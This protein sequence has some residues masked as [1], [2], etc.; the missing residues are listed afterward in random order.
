MTNPYDASTFTLIGT[1][2][3]ATLNAYEELSVSFANYTDTGRYVA[4]RSDLSAFSLSNNAYIDNLTLGL[5]PTCVKPTNILF[6]NIMQTTATG[7]WTP[8]TSAVSYEVVYGLPGIDPLTATPVP[9]TDTFVDMINLTA[10]TLYHFYV[11]S[12]CAGGE[13]SDWTFVRTFRT[14]CDAISVLP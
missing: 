12:V 14:A 8:S 2:N 3:P 1:A 4:I 11:R 5:I 7:Y 9:V 10:N 13:Y 6:T